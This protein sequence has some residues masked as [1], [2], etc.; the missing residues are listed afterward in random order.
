MR[1]CFGADGPARLVAGDASAPDYLLE[2][3]WAERDAPAPTAERWRMR[4]DAGSGDSCLVY[5]VD[6]GRAADDGA[7]RRSGWVGGDLLTT[8]ELW[9]WRPPAATSLAFELPDGIDVSSPWAPLDA[10]RPDHRVVRART[11]PPQW[12]SIVA[13]GR[14]PSWPAGPGARL[15]VLNQEAFDNAGDMRRWIAEAVGAV[16]SVHGTFPRRHAQV[17]VVPSSR[18]GSAVPWGQ[19]LRGGAPAAH[20]FVNPTR[21]LKEFRADWT[22]S[23]E[24]SHFLLPFV[25]RADAWVSEGFASYYQN[26]AR[27]RGGML[28]HEQAWDK[29]DKG[30]ARGIAGT[31]S[32]RSLRVASRW[33]R[34]NGDYMRVYWSGAAIALLADVELRRQS[35]NAQDL[36]AALGAL[37]GC[38]LDPGRSWSAD[39]LFTQLDR[40]TGRRI[41]RGLLEAHVDSAHFPDVAP[42][43]DALGVRVEDGDVVLDD[44]APL[45]DI[46]R[47]IMTAP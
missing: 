36:G 27:A 15:A 46:R 3:R 23:H 18:G 12:S 31:R 45:A 19:V 28:S 34:Q 41:F 14:F 40:L 44:D 20:F 39:E 33:M 22:A 38:C 13:F 30:F 25:R 11:T 1:A 37:A 29:L 4:L 5:R 24:F 35:D 16:A 32:H 26:V 8:P 7:L 9:F 6:V 47:A 42:T 17:L 2:A 10:E 43:L 21:P